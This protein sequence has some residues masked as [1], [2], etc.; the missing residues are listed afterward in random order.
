MADAI[1]PFTQPLNRRLVL[2]P[3]FFDLNVLV[4]SSQTTVS[5]LPTILLAAVPLSFLLF[6]DASIC[7]GQVFDGL[8]Y[9]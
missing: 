5:A 8:N 3:K 1:N 9:A 2:F 6:L 4:K 7:A